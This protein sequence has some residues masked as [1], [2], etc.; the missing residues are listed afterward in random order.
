MPFNLSSAFTPRYWQTDQTNACI[1]ILWGKGNPVSMDAHTVIYVPSD[2]ACLVAPTGSGKTLTSAMIVQRFLS[3]H[4]DKS[5]MIAVHRDKLVE[6]MRKAIHTAITGIRCSII[7][8]NIKK[9]RPA[10]VY[11]AMVTTLNN[12]I[13]KAHKIKD[14]HDLDSDFYKIISNVGLLIIDESHRGEHR[15]LE[16]TFIDVAN[17]QDRTIKR[18]GFTATPKSASARDPLINH[19]RDTKG[20]GCI[21]RY[22]KNGEWITGPQISEL[23]HWHSMHPKEGLCDEIQIVQDCDLLS[24]S[25]KK[26]M[27][28]NGKVDDDMQ[29]RILK[30]PKFIDKLIEQY[31]TNLIG[32]KTLIFNSSIEHSQEVTRRMNECGYETWHLDGANFPPEYPSYHDYRAKAFHWL[33]TVPEAI[34]CGVGIFTTGIDVPSIIGVMLNK[35]TISMTEFLQIFGRGSRPNLGKYFFVSVDM[36]NSY[37]IHGH[38][39]ADRDMESIF[40]NPKKPGNG[41]APLKKCPQCKGM[42][43]ASKKVCDQMIELED[44]LFVPCLFLF[45]VKITLEPDFIRFKIANNLPPDEILRIQTLLWTNQGMDKYGA[46][47]NLI[48]GVVSKYATEV[49]IMPDVEVY[50]SLC[51]TA[52]QNSNVWKQLNSTKG[53]KW[54]T[55]RIKKRIAI[56]IK[57]FWPEAEINCIY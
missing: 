50:D 22:I 16:Q 21:V 29:G 1:S 20:N 30:R 37:M 27:I 6:G 28:S 24:D 35:Y 49:N 15:K 51:E 12:R 14:D 42:V 8:A 39:N 43:A 55:D 45:P 10:N 23:I 19:Y 47:N 25:E 11:C 33:E 56:K 3:A 5:V 34:L 18:I 17:R 40:L 2:N 48:D 54:I 26:G 46:L 36:H 32:K 41:V 9:T 52:L 4:P 53:G 57:S 31:E 38:W 13:K 7:D 44:D